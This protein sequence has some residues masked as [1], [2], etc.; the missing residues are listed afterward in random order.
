M[1]MIISDCGGSGGGCGGGGG[2][3]GGD[4]LMRMLVLMTREVLKAGSSFPLCP[5]PPGQ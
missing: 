5:T 2:G 4:V 1:T 3:G